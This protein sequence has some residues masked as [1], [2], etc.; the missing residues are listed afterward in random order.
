LGERSYDIHLGAGV[1]TSLGALCLRH[2]LPKRLVI[3]ADTNSARVALP[4]ALA[5]LRRAGF[6]ILPITMPAGE[7][8]K[9]LSRAGKIHAEMLRARVPRSAAM[10]ALGGGVVG[11]VAGFVASTY[12]RGLP[13]VQC[14]T[15]LLSQVDSSVGGKN[16]VNHPAAKNAVGTF[17]Q[18]VFVLADTDLLVT[19]PRRDIVSGIG[20]IIKYP[21]VDDPGLLEFIEEHLEDLA[22]VDGA[23]VGTIAAR[24]LAI[25]TR[26][27]SQD[28]RETKP[29]GGRALLNVG[30]TVGHALESLSRYSLR[31]GEAVFLGVIVEGSIAVRRGWMQEADLNRFV[32]AY[33]RLRCRFHSRAVGGTIL[34]KY[35]FKGSAPRFVLPRFP[36]QA[37]V[38]TDVTPAEVKSAMRVLR[39]L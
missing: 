31:H 4:P 29:D 10:I 21:L 27:V 32:N 6:D 11:D 12:R 1:V 26:L 15:T 37:G 22:S 38:V 5:S 3:L 34:V 24:C 7:R 13:L 17:H 18:P 16:G 23:A 2:R 25:K 39:S 8:Q 36:H 14:P 20:E 19:L 30:H 35:L 33:R 9:S 28:E